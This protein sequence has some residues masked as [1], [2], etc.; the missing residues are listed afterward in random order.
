MEDVQD[1]IYA[2]HAEFG[3]K[4]F[5]VFYLKKNNL[6]HAYPGPILLRKIGMR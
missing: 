6:V 5:L 1:A 2:S 4:K 3:C